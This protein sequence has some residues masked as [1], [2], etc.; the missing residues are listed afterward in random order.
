MS[1]FARLLPTVY[2]VIAMFAVLMAGYR[3]MAGMW[4]RGL[5]MAGA[6]VFCA[7]RYHTLRTDHSDS[8]G[9]PTGLSSRT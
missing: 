5:F 2:L 3:F 8:D 6:A 1:N 9:N 7:Y 4:V